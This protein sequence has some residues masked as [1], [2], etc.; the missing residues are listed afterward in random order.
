MADSTIPVVNKPVWIDLASSDPAASR[1]F[2]ARV[3]GVDDV[4]ASFATALEAGA[5][6]MMAPT[7]FPGGKFAIVGDPQG[8]A[9]GLHSRSRDQG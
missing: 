5:R 2:Y 1:A 9:F 6:E 3:F 4:E 8:A 7:A